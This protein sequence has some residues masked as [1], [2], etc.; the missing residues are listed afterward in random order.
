MPGIFSDE[1]LKALAAAT[2]VTDTEGRTSSQPDVVERP[3]PGI[4][5]G[6]YAALGVGQGLDTWSTLGAIHRGGAEGNSGVYGA[7]P[8]PTRLIGTKAVMTLPVMLAM[9]E[10]SKTHPKIAKTLGY[11]GGILGGLLATLNSRVE[12]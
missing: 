2:A 6:P 3:V 5:A 9:H 11:G 10:L 8:S 7:H 4:G 1:I 12:R